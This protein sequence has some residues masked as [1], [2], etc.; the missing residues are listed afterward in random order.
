MTLKYELCK[1][2]K[3]CEL[4]KLYELF[5]NRLKSLK[6]TWICFKYN[7]Y[8][9]QEFFKKFPWIYKDAKRKYWQKILKQY[10][11]EQI[12]TGKEKYF[13]TRKRFYRIER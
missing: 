3:L 6:I 10:A 4:C 9:F 11:K 5:M 8:C 2:C 1:L 7:I 13:R 12:F